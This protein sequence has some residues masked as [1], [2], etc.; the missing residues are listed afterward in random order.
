MTQWLSDE[1]RKVLMDGVAALA[2]RDA[3]F[4]RA[5]REAAAGMLGVLDEIDAAERAAARRLAEEA[6]A[7]AAAAEAAIPRYETSLRIGDELRVV[8][9]RGTEQEA[10]LAAQTA[11]RRPAPPPLEDDLAARAREG[12]PGPVIADIDLVLLARRCHLKAAACRWIVE[13]RRMMTDFTADTVREVGDRDRDFFARAKALPNC[14]LWMMDPRG[15]PPPGDPLLEVLAGCYDNVARGAEVV[16]PLSQTGEHEDLFEAGLYLLAESQSALRVALVDVSQTFV[17]TDQRDAF[18]WLKK[19]TRERS[20]YVARH[21]RMDDPAHPDDWEPVKARLEE[22]DA[23]RSQRHTM[24]RSRQ[25]LLN[26]AKYHAGRIAHANG[27]VQLEDWK[28]LAAALEEM[29]GGGIPP[30]DSDMREVLLPVLETMPSEDEIEVG[31]GMRQVLVEADR[32]LSMAAARESAGE[33][34]APREKPAHI[35]EAAELLRGRTIMLIGGEARPHAKRALEQAFEL[36]E[37]AWMTTRAHQ[38]TAEFEPVVAR[39]ETA[40]VLLAIRW[41]SHSFGDVKAMCDRYGKPFVRLPAGYNP[42]QVARQ[43][44]QQASGALRQQMAPAG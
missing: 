17:D 23:R 1:N 13:R 34:A 39:P 8:Q 11:A 3:E 40:L 44:L 5:L 30:S 26:K 37:L 6:A 36:E 12:P 35:R 27:E 43:I 41:S 25:I 21:M 10:R 33:S 38:S 20:I 15:L 31:P 16:E 42:D 14:Y 29:V 2:A 24:R 4:R 22:L 28:K 7:A 19:Q 9:V 18:L 32:Y